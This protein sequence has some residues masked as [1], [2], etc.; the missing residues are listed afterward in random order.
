MNKLLLSL[1]VVVL[2]AGCDRPNSNNM[3]EQR[4]T[5]NQ[6]TSATPATPVQPTAPVTTAPAATQNAVTP[7]N[8]A[9][10]TT[11]AQGALPGQ[12]QPDVMVRSNAQP[13]E[14]DNRRP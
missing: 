7:A 5:V 11:P 8:R 3:S 12:E 14:S 6:V 10:T 4:N 2:L 13:N 9:Q 1:G